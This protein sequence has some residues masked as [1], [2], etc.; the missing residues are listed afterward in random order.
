MP[1]RELKCLKA[2]NRFSD[3]DINQKEDLKEVAQSV[4]E[5]CNASVAIIT[6][7]DD[8]TGD[9]ISQI[10]YSRIQPDQVDDFSQF[11]IYS[12]DEVEVKDI[13]ASTVFDF[14]PIAGGFDIR[15][16][17]SVPLLTQDGSNLGVITVLDNVVRQL[18]D[19]HWRML[20]VL[21]RQSAQILE[22]GW[23]IQVLK[24]HIAQSRQN[25]IKLR[26]FFESSVS[27][28][29]LLGKDLEIL[30]FN[31]VAAIF[32]KEL[33]GNILQEGVGVIDFIHASH[34]DVFKSNYAKAINGETVISEQELTYSDGRSIYW[35][36]VFEPA[37]N[38]EGNI[39]GVSLNATDITDRIRQERL[40]FSQNES[41]RRIAFI[42][43]HELR[44]PVSTIMGLIQLIKSEDLPLSIRQDVSMLDVAVQELDSKIKEIVSHTS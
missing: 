39:I 18:E 32:N 1:L 42:Q 44:R 33:Y 14:P 34:V 11:V 10:S 28:H 21:S 20:R 29:L 16:Y 24:E 37:R 27:C 15:F 38:Q 2:V 5:I 7:L 9:F 6:I 4:V 26:S 40:V 35:Y 25:E 36:V 31:K 17:A 23:S 12:R 41:L 30:A 43:S 3:L 19:V 8:V 13:K 22:F